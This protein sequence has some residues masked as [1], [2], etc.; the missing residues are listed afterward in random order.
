[1]NALSVLKTDCLSLLL[2]RFKPLYKMKL[3]EFNTLI[4]DRLT[5]VGLFLTDNTN[6]VL[7]PLKYIPKDYKIGDEI[8]VFLYLDHEER[9]VATTLEPYIIINDFAFL[10]VNYT[11]SFGAFLDWG[12]E[13]DLFVP[14]KEQARP[15]E[16]GKRYLVHA[17][18]DDKSDRIVGS[19]RVNKFL[20]NSE[21]DLQQG[22]EVDLI[23]SHIT[24]LGTNVIINKKHKGLMYS[25]E[26]YEDLRIGDK[27]KGYIKTIRPD[28][29]IDVS[30]Q[31]IGV[32]NIEPNAEVILKELKANRGFLRL[33]DNSHPEDIKTVLKMS[34]KS[35]KKAVGLLYKD[36][37]I[38]IKEDGIYLV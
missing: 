35:F 28:N 24:D 5:K 14:F 33:N 16:Q 38:E 3:G 15:M 20:D 29:K 37:I 25:N 34:K 26:I 19:S 1:M 18:L 31:K 36:K 27:H 22:D 7:L 6:D 23:I 9:P 12:L 11:N 13:K 32:E 2:N 8:K 30:F 17:Y 21:L 10:R 4:I